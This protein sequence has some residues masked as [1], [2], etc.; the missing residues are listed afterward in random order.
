M[1]NQRNHLVAALPTPERRRFAAQAERVELKSGQ[2]LMDVTDRPRYAYFPEGGLISLVG[3]T[4]EGRVVE[5]LHTGREGMVGISILLHGDA[6]IA[7]AV[8]HIPA[9]ACRVRA[10]VLRDELRHSPSLE[11]LLLRYSYTLFRQLAQSMTCI[12]V[13]SSERRFA[14]WLL[15]VHDRVGDTTIELTQATIADLLSVQRGLVSSTAA[16]WQDAGLIRVRHGKIRVVNRAGVEA[17]AC[18]C[19]AAI[20]A[21]QAGL[22]EALSR[23]GTKGD[24]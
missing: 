14:R 1:S 19:Y 9:T 5:L 15:E 6:A 13:H 20:K 22:D 4:S 12:S 10:D 8:A 2:V 7:R 3:Q 11:K 21:E 16:D 24:T 23:T 17:R 18:E